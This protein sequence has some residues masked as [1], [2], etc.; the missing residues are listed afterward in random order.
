M[1]GRPYKFDPNGLY[2]SQDEGNTWVLLNYKKLYG[3]TGNGNYVVGD[4]NTFGTF[5][6]SSLGTGIIYGKV[7]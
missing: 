4:M 5:Y 7:K 2:R 6:M 1:Y 3:G